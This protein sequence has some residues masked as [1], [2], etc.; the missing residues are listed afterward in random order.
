M[1]VQ[2]LSRT[3]GGGGGVLEC[4]ERAARHILGNGVGTIIMR[5]QT[6]RESRAE[7]DHDDAW[8]GLRPQPD[9]CVRRKVCP[10]IC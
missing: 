9:T 10:L 1:H 2:P 6:E 3:G 4:S 7:P 8:A 5:T